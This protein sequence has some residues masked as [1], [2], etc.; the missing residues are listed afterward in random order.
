MSQTSWEIIP[1]TRWEGLRSK[2]SEEREAPARSK[3]KMIPGLT[4]L[5][6]VHQ[7][8]RVREKRRVQL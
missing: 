4:G 7:N 6:T 5:E 1:S 3:L 8:Y 2:L